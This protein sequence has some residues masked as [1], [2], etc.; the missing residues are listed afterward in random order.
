MNLPDFAFFSTYSLVIN[1]T[2]WSPLYVTNRI[3]ALIILSECAF[4]SC[5]LF[6]IA[7]RYEKSNPLRSSIKDLFR[8][9][10]SLKSQ[11]FI[12]VGVRLINWTFHLKLTFML[13]LIASGQ[14]TTLLCVVL[15][16][17]L[18]ILT[19]IHFCMMICK[20]SVFKSRLVATYRV[21]LEI[22]LLFFFFS[23]LIERIG[24]LASHQDTILKL[25]IYSE[26]MVMFCMILC[27]LLQLINNIVEICLCLKS[28]SCKKKPNSLTLQ[29]LEK[30]L[31]ETVFAS[32]YIQT[33]EMIQSTKER[34]KSSILPQSIE[35]R[36]IKMKPL[37]DGT[38]ESTEE[39]P[40]SSRLLL[41][42]R[43]EGQTP[44]SLGS[45]KKKITVKLEA[46]STTSLTKNCT[47]QNS[48]GVETTK[49]QSSSKG[50]KFFNP[51]IAA[52]RAKS[53][54]KTETELQKQT[55]R[56]IK[57]TGFSRAPK[58]SLPS[59]ELFVPEA[60][61]PF[62]TPRLDRKAQNFVQNIPSTV[63]INQVVNPTTNI[64]E[65]KKGK[66]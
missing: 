27:I 54:K 44:F 40:Q 1:W 32:D 14:I 65:E 9:E 11:D 43:D 60:S 17:I 47:D 53:D 59:I 15:L 64:H 66:D 2:E 57:I 52:L 31:K 48:E 58:A 35:K 39:L 33:L 29:Q 36:R 38:A 20:Y 42:K 28:S 22:S 61:I 49:S 7:I 19:S 21:F 51:I 12:H 41:S 63:S 6:H 50:F 25:S 13:A 16:N 8:I 62:S 37:V 24:Y 4:D 55:R 3:I 56:K 23:C 18:C 34:K 45:E 46:E 30:K 26:G 10:D 5:K